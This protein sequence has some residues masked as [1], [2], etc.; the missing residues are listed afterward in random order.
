MIGTGFVG[1]SGRFFAVRRG[2][3]PAGFDVV[4]NPRRSVLDRDFKSL[5]AE[6][7]SVLGDIS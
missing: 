2:G 1:E 6:V 4:V 7:V 5:R 3:F